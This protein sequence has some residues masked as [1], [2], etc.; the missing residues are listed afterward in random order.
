V[1]YSLHR[2]AEQ[3]LAEAFRFYQREGGN[4]LARRFLDEF[5][6]I[7]KILEEFPDIGK[8]TAESRRSF[9]FSGFPYSVIC[10]YVNSEIRVL[11][12]RHQNRDPVYGDHRV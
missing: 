11:V 12:V 3:D 9:S 4:G 6:R 8:P 10:R 7:I 2:G 5:A 1:S